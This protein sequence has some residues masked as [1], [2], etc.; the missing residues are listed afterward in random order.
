MAMRRNPPRACQ[1]R[2][3]LPY[4]NIQ[5]QLNNAVFKE[6]V[7]NPRERQPQRTRSTKRCT[8][9]PRKC[10]EKSL[11]RQ[12]PR[13]ASD[14]PFPFFDLPREIRDQVYSSLVVRQPGSKR[15]V[16][17]AAPLLQ[18]R[19]RR[20]TAQ[21]NRERSNQRRILSGRPPIQARVNESEP[22]VDLSLLQ[23]SQRLNF[24]AK[25]CLYTH[26]WFAI[27][28]NKLPLTTFETPYGWDLSR[29]TRL[30]IEV[31]MKDAAHMN[32]YVDWT[33][34]FTTFP[35]VRFLRIIPTFHPRY[36]DWAL[37]ELSE[38]TTTHYIHKAFFRELLASI[39]GHIKLELGLMSETADA[40]QLQ[41]KAVSEGLVRDMYAEVGR[42]RA[43]TST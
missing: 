33:T 8:I 43:I 27:T 21:A 35:A 37:L 15:S 9:K 13:R 40:V 1:D 25:D 30:Q 26:N 11:S 42:W 6:T 36:Y 31:Q 19:K 4:A 34:I 23:T 28:L 12:I 29:I 41:G 14:Q 2:L 32:S 20:M 17:A 39:A 10:R 24:E 5:P 18:S 22:V 7:D 3:L 38:W 16:I